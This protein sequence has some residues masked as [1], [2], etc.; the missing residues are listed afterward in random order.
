MR[1]GFEAIY[2]FHKEDG[3]LVPQR[4]NQPQELTLSALHH[5]VHQIRLRGSL[6]VASGALLPREAPERT[7][8]TN[9]S[10]VVAE[11]VDAQR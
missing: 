8:R 1:N 11:L 7:S 6:A 2:H 10:A 4:D 5:P 3:N 9:L